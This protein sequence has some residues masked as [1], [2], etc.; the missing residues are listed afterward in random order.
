MLGVEVAYRTRATGDAYPANY[1]DAAR[2]M[3]LVRQRAAEWGIDPN[4]VGALGF[5]AGG[6]LASLLSTQPK[7]HIERADDLAA[8]IHARPDF[9]ILAYPVI[10]FVEGYSPGAFVSS[11]ENFFGRRDLDE[12][13]RTGFS[14]ELHVTADHSPVFIWTTADDALVP[15]EHSRRFVEACRRANT[16]VAFELFAHGPHGMGLALAQPGEVG[17]W[18]HRALAWLRNREI[19]EP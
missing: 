13:L 15:A 11:A 5:S 9:V 10:S 14:N 1:A 12:E 6:H 2:A 8:H 19:L 17:T 18:T 4:R 3:R 16:P 7:L